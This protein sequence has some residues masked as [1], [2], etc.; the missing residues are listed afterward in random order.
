MTLDQARI[1]KFAELPNDLRELSNDDSLQDSEQKRLHAT[2]TRAQSLRPQSADDQT[3]AQQAH[4]EN[5][6]KQ[7]EVE[8]HRETPVVDDNN[9]GPS[10]IGAFGSYEKRQQ[11]DGV[12]AL[13][14]YC[15]QRLS[16]ASALSTAA[17]HGMP[18]KY[19]AH[20]PCIARSPSCRDLYF[21]GPA[22]VSV[23]HNKISKR[24]LTDS[25]LLTD[26]M[27]LISL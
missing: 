3:V 11:L 25:R 21:V 6:R 20:V 4:Q 7:K 10:D 5:N 22:L 16:V 26:G 27:V 18:C 13:C 19:T 2:A 12:T 24:K 17:S 23:P 15:F 8:T 1:I 9:F 14:V